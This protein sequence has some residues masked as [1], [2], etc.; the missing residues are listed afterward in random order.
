MS[1]ED[2]P[3]GGYFDAQFE[4]IQHRIAA[5]DRLRRKRRGWALVATG[6]MASLAITGGTI[7]VIQASETEKSG[8]ICYESASTSSRQTEVGAAPAD[9]V[10]GAL[11]GMPERVR[12]AEEECG[13]AWSIG[14]FSPEGSSDSNDHTVPELFTCV[15][16]D[17]RLGVFPVTAG[18]S[19]ATLEFRE[20]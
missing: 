20:P 19:C 2:Q 16:R 6:A 1:N 13:V 10:V 7:A 11:P 12:A 15:L 5:S 14:V 17:G 9:G 8:S 3:A 4:A 18:V